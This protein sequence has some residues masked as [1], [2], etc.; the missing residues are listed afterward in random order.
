MKRLLRKYIRNSIN[1][2]FIGIW[3]CTG[4]YEIFGVS[5]TLSGGYNDGTY[6]QY[7]DKENHLTL[8]R[9]CVYAV[10]DKP[11]ADVIYNLGYKGLERG[12]VIYDLR[13]QCYVVTC[14]KSVLYDAK[15]RD[16]IKEYFD[17]NN[18][19]VDFQALDHYIKVPLTGNPTIDKFNYE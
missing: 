18:C 8:W 1:D 9:K 19:R 15:F 5:C 14:S 3:W 16:A 2:G 6:I 17:L 13:T 11:K 7:S 4:D 10:F 12:R